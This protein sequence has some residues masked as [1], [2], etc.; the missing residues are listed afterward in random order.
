M[1]EPQKLCING[2]DRTA[3]IVAFAESIGLKSV[4]SGRIS[5]YFLAEFFCRANISGEVDPFMVMDEIKHLEG[6]GRRTGTKEASQFKGK[7]LSGLWHKH[8]REIGI[9]S[10]AINLQHAL[11]DHGIPSLEAISGKDRYGTED[12]V[13][14][15]AYEVTVGNYERRS[16]ADKLTGEWIVFAKNEGKNYYLC[17]G[18][19]H[20]GDDVIRQKIENVCVVEFPFLV[21]VLKA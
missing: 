11:G 21:D 18:K 14:Q 12:V 13:K 2:V 8:H 10:I 20:S 6:C 3:E 9:R 16:D 19:H 7:V 15:M 1:V 5:N 17:L 4:A